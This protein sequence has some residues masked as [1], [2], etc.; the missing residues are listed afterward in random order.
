MGET[1]GT[2]V[3]PGK[4]TKCCGTPVI[5]DLAQVGEPILAVISGGGSASYTAR[6]AY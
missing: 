1:V 6:T 3:V 4:S 5:P 2:V